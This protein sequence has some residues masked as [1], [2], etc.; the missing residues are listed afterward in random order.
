[1]R[2]NKTIIALSVASGTAIVALAVAFQAPLASG[3]RIM[4]ENI[5][6]FSTYQNLANPYVRYVKIP[7]G[8]RK[9]EVAAIYYNVL[10]W[11]DQDIEQ[12]TDSNNASSTNLEGYYFPATYVLPVNANGEEVKKEMLNKFSEKVVDVTKD[13][14]TV[15]DKS[16]VNMDTILTVASLI[17]REAAGK[18]DM[19]LISGIIWNR[20]WNGMSLDIDATLQYAKGNDEDGWWPQVKSQDKKIDSPYNT[21]KNKG[22]PPS[23]ISNPGINAINAA[24]NPT[25]TSCVFYFHDKKHQIHCSKTY[26]EHKAGVEKYLRS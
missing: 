18:N 4:S 1:M 9:E 25:E 5:D 22:L 23:P 11:N 16:K 13:A 24:Y 20:I 10:A 2:T 26:G 17:Q 12:F 8:L 21:Y 6:L 15:I 14:K 19:N 7:A 3:I